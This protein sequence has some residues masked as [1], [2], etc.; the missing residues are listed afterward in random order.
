[1]TENDVALNFEVYSNLSF[2]L[3]QVMNYE[4]K[5]FKIFHIDLLEP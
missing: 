3:T 5:Y 4:S 1:M 2:Y